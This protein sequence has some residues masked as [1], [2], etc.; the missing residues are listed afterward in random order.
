M[1][2]EEL[3]ERLREINRSNI[4]YGKTLTE[5][6]QISIRIIHGGY[7]PK[8]PLKIIEIIRYGC[9]WEKAESRISR[10]KESIK[11]ILPDCAD[12]I[13]ERV[14]FEIKTFPKVKPKPLEWVMIE[15]YVDIFKES[16][17]KE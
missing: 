8:K 17:D 14:E 4:R 13:L 1:T 3:D 7:T 11:E 2:E 10:L 12:Y 15:D 9:D 5:A 16:E 6:M